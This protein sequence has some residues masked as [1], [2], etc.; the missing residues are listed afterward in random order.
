VLLAADTGVAELLVTKEEACV[1]T[2]ASR[3][4]PAPRRGAA[5]GFT[6]HIAPWAE[7]ELHDSY[8]L[9]AANGGSVLSDRPS[10]TSSRCRPHC[11]CAAW[12]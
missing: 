8:V 2:D 1:L 4:T 9:G 3:R 6:F 11:A 12:C 7:T 10:A 5:D